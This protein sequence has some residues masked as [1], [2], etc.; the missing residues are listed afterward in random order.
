M[1]VLGGH[2][3]MGREA[4]P[5]GSPVQKFLGPPGLS[6]PGTFFHI[7]AFLGGFLAGLQELQPESCA[8]VPLLLV[9]QTELGPLVSAPLRIQP[10]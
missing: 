9:T 5:A 10:S 1:G 8:L 6:F 2:P 3:G 4:Q 7:P